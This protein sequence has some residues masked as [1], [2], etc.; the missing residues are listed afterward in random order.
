MI[1][2][3]Y[4]QIRTNPS[5]ELCELFQVYLFLS[6]SL[7]LSHTHTHTSLS[8][9]LTHTFTDKLTFEHCPSSFFHKRAGVSIQ[10]TFKN[11]FFDKNSVLTFAE[12]SCLQFAHAFTALRHISEDLTLV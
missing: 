12:T 11:I 7:S 3:P 8:L 4:N 10:I 6:L 5:R 1:Y 9:S 2:S